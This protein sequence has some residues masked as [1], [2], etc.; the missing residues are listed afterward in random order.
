MPCFA[1]H[2]S[3]LEFLEA[4]SRQVNRSKKRACANGHV[5]TTDY[6]RDLIRKDLEKRGLAQ[7]EGVFNHWI[8]SILPF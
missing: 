7:Q 4:S 3:L 8:A 5:N 6:V 1:T 2:I